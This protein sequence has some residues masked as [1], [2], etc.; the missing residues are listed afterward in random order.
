MQDT[1]HDAAAAIMQPTMTKKAKRPKQ[2]RAPPHFWRP[3]RD[4]AAAR[5]HE[6]AWVVHDEGV[7]HGAH[8]EGEQAVREELGALS[9]RPRHN[10]SGG[11]GE[12]HR[13]AAISTRSKCVLCVE[14]INS[15]K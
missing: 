2:T 1:W 9:H 8:P 15:E 3:K 11:G 13:Q 6:P 5:A 10:G 14:D 4:L 12:R 7:D